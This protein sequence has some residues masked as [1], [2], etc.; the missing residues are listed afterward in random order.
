M[1]IF[2]AGAGGVIGRQLLPLL[3][4]DGHHVVAL[5]RTPAKA[6]SLRAAGA[7]PVIADALDAEALADV[8]VLAR[9]D[10][11]IHQLTNLPPA[12]EPRRYAAAYTQTARLRIQGTRNLLRAATAAGVRR[13]VAQSIAFGYA[14]GE[15]PAS[16]EEEFLADGPKGLQAM[17]AAVA[18]LE[19]QVLG[20]ADLHGVV[21]RY[22]HLYGPGT[23]YAPDGPIAYQVRQRRFPIVG[24][25][26][27]VFSFVHVA[28]A[29]EA[30]L[31]AL[32]PTAAGV[33]NIVDDEPAPLRVWLPWYARALRA[34]PPQQVPAILARLAVGG[35]A[36]VLST[37]QRGAS[38]TRARQH[39]GWQPRYR[40]WRTGF[41]STTGDGADRLGPLGVPS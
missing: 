31:A 23:W 21:L 34:P 6:E 16:E 32:G 1:R 9:P 29:A 14:S 18:D 30:T 4:R 22:G 28:D 35:Q 41:A 3:I 5:T 15:G 12:P 7:Q 27:G 25:G 17:M 33:Y 20:T 2:T 39:L 24:G 11:V 40:S 19:R 26:A 37:R 36:V 10:L 38:N 8:V 13:V